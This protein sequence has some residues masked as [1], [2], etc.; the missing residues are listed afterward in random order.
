LKK[1][2]RNTCFIFRIS[3]LNKTLMTTLREP[4]DYLHTQFSEQRQQT[5]SLMLRTTGPSSPV[6]KLVER[7]IEE[8]GTISEPNVLMSQ[9]CR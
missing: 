6:E 8:P 4:S 1:N 7:P 9:L 3:V 2:K 5:P